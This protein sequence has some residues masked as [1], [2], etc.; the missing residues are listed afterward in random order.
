MFNLQAEV[1]KNCG[2]NIVTAKEVSIKFRG[3]F[4]LAKL[5]DNHLQKTGMR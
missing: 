1:V 5:K 3:Y 4:F 2:N